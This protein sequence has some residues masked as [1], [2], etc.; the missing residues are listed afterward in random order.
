MRENETLLHDRYSIVHIEHT[1]SFSKVF[2]A[3]DTYQNPPRSCLIKVFEPIIQKE[4]IAKWIEEEFYKELKHLKQL[5][6]R[7]QHLPEIY[8]YSSEFQVYYIV[9]ELIEGETLG[10]KVQTEGKFSPQEVRAILVK[11][12]PVLQYLHHEGVIHQNIKPKNIILRSDDHMPMLINFGSIKQIVATYKFYGDKQIS[13]VSNVNGYAPPEQALGKPVAASDLYSLGLTAA[14]LLS[15]KKPIDFAVDSDSGDIQLPHN[16]FEQDS[17]LATI[18]TRAISTNLEDRYSSVE[19]ML[20]DLLRGEFNFNSSQS[21]DKQKLSVVANQPGNFNEDNNHHKSRSHRLFRSRFTRLR[22]LPSKEDKSA[23]TQ[24]SKGY[25]FGYRRKTHLGK[26][27]RNTASQEVNAKKD[28]LKDNRAADSL[29]QIAHEPNP[30]DMRKTVQS[31]TTQSLASEDNG[32][33]S[34]ARTPKTSPPVVRRGFFNKAN[35]PQILKEDSSSIKDAGSSDSFGTRRQV[36]QTNWWKIVVFTVSG[37]Y[38]VGAAIVAL[39]DWNISQSVSVRSLPEPLTPSSP[40]PQASSPSSPRSSTSKPIAPLALNSP[41]E[42]VIEIPILATGS[43]KQE[44]RNILG[45]PNAIQKGYWANSIAWIYKKQAS[46]SIDLGY[47]FDLDTNQL[48]QTEVA[49]APD[50]GLETIQDILDSLLQ[51]DTTP[52]INQE[53]Q[54]IY[55]RQTSEY[56]FEVGDFEGSIAREADDHIYLGVWEANFH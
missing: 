23:E 32:A 43:T 2:F 3:L 7:N 54:K 12:L 35:A 56:S 16:I 18:V 47:L 13:S 40:V 15:A 25:I 27:W 10:K 55:R 45:E 11:L 28:V 46:D 39:Y 44:L 5:S 42:D 14:Y 4:R 1:G 9:R 24:S 31:L 50:V 37:L 48:R 52:L 53:L 30:L 17:D 36:G 34:R 22:R 20:D 21:P 8:T 29:E 38:I 41:P 33:I 6:L 26:A 51:G 49:I 19:E